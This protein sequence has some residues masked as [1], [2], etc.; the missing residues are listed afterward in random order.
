MNH[1]VLF[2]IY[3]F[4]FGDSVT[5][6]LDAERIRMWMQQSDDTDRAIGQRFGSLLE[7]AA[8][9]DWNLDELTREEAVALVVLFDQFPRNLH[10]TSSEAYAYDHIARDLARRLI[11]SG[12]ERFTPMEQLLLGLPFAHH[13]DLEDQAYAL[14]LATEIVIAAPHDQGAQRVLDQAIRHRELIRRFGRFPHRNAML[15]R[16]TTPEE[17][18]FLAEHG[19]GF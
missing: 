6:D 15:G 5:D 14:K 16:N 2:D 19:R 13:E 1:I 17:S 18:A 11:S 8:S 9:V 7:D 3:A 4:W 10:R 12:W